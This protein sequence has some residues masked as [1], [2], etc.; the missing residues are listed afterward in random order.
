MVNTASV[1]I[2]TVRSFRINFVEVVSFHLNFKHC[3][4]NNLVCTVFL[5]KDFIRAPFSFFV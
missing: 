2:N 1:M 4:Q 3:L 5:A